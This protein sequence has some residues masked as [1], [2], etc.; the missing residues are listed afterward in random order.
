M[1]WYRLGDYMVVGSNLGELTLNY[2]F[3]ILALNWIW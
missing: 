1:V 3:G 2:I